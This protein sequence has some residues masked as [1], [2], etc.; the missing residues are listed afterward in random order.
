MTAID[1]VLPRLKAEEGFRMRVYRDT[2]GHQ[3]IGYG[4]NV[5]AGLTQRVASALLQAQLEELQDILSAFL[6]YANLDPVRQGVCLDI[7]FNDGIH[8]LLAFPQMIAALGRKDW[9]SAQSECHV[10]NPELQERYATLAKILLTGA[11]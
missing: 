1:S 10:Q 5:D 6:W 2:E 8:G 4:F 3:T 7:A 9:I 11:Q